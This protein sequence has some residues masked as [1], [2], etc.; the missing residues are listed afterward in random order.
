MW[1]L[2]GISMHLHLSAPVNA[3]Q[4]LPFHVQNNLFRSQF[5]A[6]YSFHQSEGT[7]FTFKGTRKKTA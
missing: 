4:D 1:S 3:V 6:P 5:M 2:H 7:S